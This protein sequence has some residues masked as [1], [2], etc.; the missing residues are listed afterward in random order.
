MD[1]SA[2]HCDEEHCKSIRLWEV[3]QESRGKTHEVGFEH[4]ESEV[5]LKELEE[6]E[7]GSCVRGSRNKGLET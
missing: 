4:V 3:F 1:G 2:V 6:H 7:K 5:S